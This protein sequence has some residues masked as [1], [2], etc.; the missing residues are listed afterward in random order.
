MTTIAIDL[1]DPEYR[2]NPFPT[3][4]VL[5]DEAPVHLVPEGTSEGEDFYVLSR[6]EDVSNALRDKNRF[7]NEVMRGRFDM[8]MMINRD[9]PEHTR[10]RRNANRA[11]NARLVLTLQDWVQTVIDEVIAD[12]L[13][14]DRVE[15]IED[16][17]A[18]LPL[19]VVGDM[20]GIPRD[21][22]DDFRRWSQAVMDMFAVAAGLDPD[23]VPGFLEDLLEFG[24]YMTEL[25]IARRKEP[26]RDDILGALV[27]QQQA[28]NCT[29]DELAAMAYSFVAAGH[30]TT[31]N[32]LGGGMHML[33]SDPALA[34]RLVDN[35]DLT[36]EFIDEY[37]RIYSPIQWTLRRTT[38]DI[39]LHGV[40]IPTGALCHLVIGSAHRDPR[41]FPDPD[42]FDIDRENKGEHLGFGAGPHFCPGAALSRLLSTLTFR[43]YYP[44]L[45]RLSLDP[46]EAPV[47]RSRQG[48]Y[49]LE[50]MSLLVSP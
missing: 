32:L 14:G 23:E 6:Y 9:A 46:Q 19:R 33:L 45:D 36:G 39:E 22:K 40:T 49:G 41:Q 11:F 29:Q 30:E 47:P 13:K 3:Y 1:S 50:R 15:W 37:L 25:A 48:A 8:P 34:K 20:L 38:E 28:G 17:T 24:N 43:A 44:I 10:L 21:R 12:A 42:R 35:P 2:L 4:Q 18:T 5:R 27:E 31:M 16:V 7:S 26:N